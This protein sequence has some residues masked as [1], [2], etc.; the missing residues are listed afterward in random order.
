[1]QVTKYTGGGNFEVFN[2]RCLC[3][4]IVGVQSK[5]QKRIFKKQELK[6]TTVCSKKIFQKFQTLKNKIF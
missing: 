6:I 4:E 1:V 5:K 3:K 2:L